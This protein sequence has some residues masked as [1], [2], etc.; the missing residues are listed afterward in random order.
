MKTLL[1]LINVL[2][3]QLKKILV[4]FKNAKFG[5]LFFINIFKIPDFLTDIRVSI[6]SK[7]RLIF[8]VVVS[9]LYIV[10]SVDLIPEII[11]GA[12]GFIDDILVLIWSLGI[13][14]EEIE[15]YKRMINESK[16]PRIIDDVNYSVRD[17][18]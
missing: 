16:D 2:L 3:D 12:F 10:S 15:K 4:R 18:E 14:S 7:L 1:N 11:T 13:V 8:A 9:I 6:F 5:L 17:E